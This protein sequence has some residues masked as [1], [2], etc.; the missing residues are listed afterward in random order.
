MKRNDYDFL[1][2]KILNEISTVSRSDLFRR[3]ANVYSD[4]QAHADRIFS[5]FQKKYFCPS[6]PI[7]A[8]VHKKNEPFKGMPISCFL[9]EAQNDC[10]EKTIYESAYLSKFGGGIGTNWSNLES[11][12]DQR[13]HSRSSFDTL[14]YIQAEAKMVKLCSGY[15][16]KSGSVCCYLDIRHADAWNFIIMRKI[17]QSINPERIIPRY[18]HHS[19]IITDDFMEA[20]MKDQQW[21]FYNKKGEIVDK[22]SAR[23]VWEEI[24]ATRVETGEPFIFFKD[25]ANRKLAAHHRQLGLEIKMSNLCT[26]IILPTGMDH[27]GINR[28]AICCLSSIN[29]LEYDNWKQES[30]FLEDVNRFMDNVLTYFINESIN[31]NVGE[32]FDYDKEFGI[33]NEM[34]KTEKASVDK[35][36]ATNHPFANSVYSAYRSRDIGVGICGWS[37]LLQSKNIPYESDEASRLNREISEYIQNGF[38]K[39]S[40]KLAHERGSCPDAKECGMKIRNSYTTAI[41]PTSQIASI[42]GVSKSLEIDEPVFMNKNHTGF[43]LVKNPYLQKYLETKGRDN[44]ETWNEISQQGLQNVVSRDIFE[45]YKGP[46]DINQNAILKQVADRDKHVSQAQSLTL[47]MDQ[48]NTKANI[49]GTHINAW[50]L[51]IPTLYYFRSKPMLNASSSVEFKKKPNIEEESVQSTCIMCE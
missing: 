27:C 11:M 33:T 30:N 8:N 51:K 37:S 15:A 18:V 26:E 14:S 41:A 17:S 16:R 2:N 35:A 22:K 25:N 47:F 36:F 9:N 38:N 6:T 21:D 32:V 3:I 20:V 42:L 23:H 46:F 4:D 43:F 50:K 10:P 39:S 19:V 1:G 45:V 29:L 5:Y 24:I 31:R 49:I 28:T 40:V 44:P 48:R 34:R 13:E 7:V 12:Y